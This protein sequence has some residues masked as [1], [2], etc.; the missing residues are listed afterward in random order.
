MKL[1]PDAFS[2]L[3]ATNV[4]FVSEVACEAGGD[5]AG[6][7]SIAVY[8][9]T[10]RGDGAQRIALAPDAAAAPG[11][12]AYHLTRGEALQMAAA[13]QTAAAKLED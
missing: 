6:A 11:G 1:V 5:A 7:Q 9:V 2:K 12:P 8:V 10:R 3:D 13:L 4:D